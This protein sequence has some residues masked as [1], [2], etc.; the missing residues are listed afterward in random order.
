MSLVRYNLFQLCSVE[1]I[2]F[3]L[4]PLYKVGGNSP[5]NIPLIWKVVNHQFITIYDIIIGSLSADYSCARYNYTLSNTISSNICTWIKRYTLC[6]WSL[7]DSL[8]GLINGYPQD[9]MIYEHNGWMITKTFMSVLSIGNDQK[10]LIV[11][12]TEWVFWIGNSWI[13]VSTE[14]TYFLIVFEVF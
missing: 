13:F 4:N 1:S 12:L 14:W 10:L 9:I 7:V 11:T 3:N 2:V 8:A 6:S 5:V